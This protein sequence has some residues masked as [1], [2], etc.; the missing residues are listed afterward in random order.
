VTELAVPPPGPP[1]PPPTPATRPGPGSALRSGRRLTPGALTPHP[2]L[3][4]LPA[5]FQ[6]DLFAIRLCAALDEV[7]APVLVALDCLDTYLDPALAPADFVDWLAGW[8]GLALD[9]NWSEAQRRALVARACELYRWQGTRRG[10]VEHLRLYTGVEPE[11]SDSGGAAWS[12][13]PGG[14][15]PG[16]G[17][18]EVRVR[19]VLDAESSVDEQSVEAIVKAAKPAHVR[20]R[21]EVVRPA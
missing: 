13:S 10:L 18:P 16:D 4:L 19:L 6:E 14:I 5:L 9:Q 11:V 20:H 12:S 2:L 3:G 7:L 17:H 8:V 1:L 21:V 15:V